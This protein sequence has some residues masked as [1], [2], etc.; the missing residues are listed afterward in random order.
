MKAPHLLCVAAPPA[1]FAE[2]LRSAVAADLR[3]GWL[4]LGEP[5]DPPA[6]LAAAAEAGASR[7]VAS[8]GPWNVAVKRRRGPAVLGDLLREHF[9]GCA[10]VLVRG[11]VAAPVLA[12]EGTGWRVSSAAGTAGRV[13]STSELLALFGRRG[14]LVPSGN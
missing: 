8:G 7:A 11:H 14:E 10:A 3:I 5:P 2:L 13:V 9:V 12:P 6:E 4:D 1:I